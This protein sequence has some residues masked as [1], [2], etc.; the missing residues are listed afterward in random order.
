MRKA[1]VTCASSFRPRRLVSVRHGQSPYPIFAAYH[2]R[3]G[4]FRV[5]LACRAGKR[6]RPRGLNI[7]ERRWT[8]YISSLSEGGDREGGG[9]ASKVL[10]FVRRLPRPDEVDCAG[11]RLTLHFV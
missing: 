11:R 9:W 7:S 8:Y 3:S 10:L 4:R 6:G 1:F 2:A 5:G